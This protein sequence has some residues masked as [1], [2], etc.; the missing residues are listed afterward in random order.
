MRRSRLKKEREQAQHTE[1]GG[2]VPHGPGYHQTEPTPHEEGIDSVF[3][4]SPL[5]QRL[6][7]S[8]PIHLHQNYESSN[9]MFDYQATF[10]VV[11]VYH[12]SKSYVDFLIEFKMS[13]VQDLLVALIVIP[14]IWHNFMLTSYS[15]FI[16]VHFTD[17][18]ECANCAGILEELENIDDDCDRHGIVFVKT[19]DFSIAEQYGVLEYPA[20]VY[21]ESSV[22]NVFEGKVRLSNN[23][24]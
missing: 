12:P 7:H 2:E 5:R 18:D 10:V 8:I 6:C 1:T 23:D 20:L 11:L 21:F 13:L 22:P 24:L 17:S 3:C 14:R 4:R 19:K 9:F 15:E 16:L